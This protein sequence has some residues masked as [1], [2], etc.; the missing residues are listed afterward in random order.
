MCVYIFMWEICSVT[1][2][3]ERREE[4]EMF[5]AREKVI[6]FFVICKVQS[7]CEHSK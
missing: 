4:E 6:K 7:L 5:E 2:I 3:N 1:D